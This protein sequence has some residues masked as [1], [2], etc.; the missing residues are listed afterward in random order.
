ML[1]D[2]KD[3]QKSYEEYIEKVRKSKNSGR[4]KNT[5]QWFHHIENPTYLW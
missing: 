4:V 1:E 5:P 2:Y 3:N